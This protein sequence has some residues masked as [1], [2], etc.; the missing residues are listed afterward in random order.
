MQKEEANEQNP[1]VVEIVKRTAGCTENQGKIFHRPINSMKSIFLLQSGNIKCKIT[2]IRC[3]S[4][5]LSQYLV[6]C[7][8]LVM[9]S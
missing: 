8:F 9:Q 2:E 1:Y 7:T 6:H 3:Y 5:D 4:S